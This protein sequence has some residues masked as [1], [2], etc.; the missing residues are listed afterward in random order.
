MV[1]RNNSTIPTMRKVRNN[2]RKHYNF[3]EYL[4]TI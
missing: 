1:F 2:L 4:V 3:T